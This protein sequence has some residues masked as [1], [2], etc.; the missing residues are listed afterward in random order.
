MV[1]LKLTDEQWSVV[2]PILRKVTRETRGRKRNNDKSLFEAALYY[3]GNSGTSW[4]ELSWND[5]PPHQSCFRRF[6]EWDSRGLIVQ[7]IVTLAKDLEERGE[8]PL[9]DCFKDFLFEDGIPSEPMIVIEGGILYLDEPPAR[10]WEVATK[11]YF[12]SRQIWMIL[13]Y[14]QSEWI[15]AR[16]PANLLQRIKSVY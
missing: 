5:Y 2:N 14:C 7:A 9:R 8:V 11:E 3:L 4:R 10:P 12:E 13:Y 15:R 6:K 1:K 16:I